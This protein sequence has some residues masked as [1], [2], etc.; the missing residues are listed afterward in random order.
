MKN[1]GLCS[2]CVEDKKC[3][4]PRI[5]PVWQCEEFRNCEP[6]LESIKQIKVKKTQYSEEAQIIE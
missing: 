6:K 1:R 2:T 5:F 3:T 4:F